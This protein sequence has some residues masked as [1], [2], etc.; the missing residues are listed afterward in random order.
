MRGLRFSLLLI[1]TLVLVG[2]ELAAAQPSSLSSA[3]TTALERATADRPDD[4]GGPQVHVIYAVAAD[5]TDE[6]LDT[7]G[8]GY[9]I[10]D[11]AQ[12][13]LW[14]QVGFTL[15]FDTY[16]RQADVSFLR[17][18]ESEASLA[19]RGN[20]IHP[21]VEE[22]VR[23][24]GFNKPQT[25]YLVVYGASSTIA[26]GYGAW[27]PRL[28]GNVALVFKACALSR[29]PVHEI[30][31]VLGAVPE[32]A[33]HDT[34]EGHATDDPS[35]LMFVNGD[36]GKTIDGGR[37]DYFNPDGG[38]IAGCLDPLS[39]LANS[40]YLVRGGFQTLKVSV[41]GAGSV[42]AGQET[43]F[44][45][46]TCSIQLATGANVELTA[47]PY[48]SAS[49]FVGWSGGCSGTAPTCLITMNSDQA[50]T[51]SF[52]AV[53]PPLVSLTVRI[54]G[55]GSVRISG[56]PVCTSPG[57]KSC[58]FSFTKDGRLVKLTAIPTAG[59]HFVRWNGACSG[60]KGVCR[61]APDANK[62]VIATFAANI[63]ALK[64]RAK[65]KK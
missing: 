7:S 26:C 36:R 8:Y 30:F 58:R 56:K 42:D 9:G 33:A 10:V 29:S 38:P 32:C 31:H 21:R 11:Y 25:I 52:L 51:A 24:A 41:T 63:Q 1:S 12:R 65:T 6:G 39:N 19:A 44:Q 53:P 54:K 18:P 37:D 5:G 22:L 23:G 35:D 45:N 50:V 34:G 27:P 13:L 16:Q 62:R 43:C 49:R 55:K 47:T 4:F 59:N 20:M 64:I 46:E 60:A 40:P 3:G 17:L 14:N 2:Q 61:L 48:D 28:P 57:A 15:R